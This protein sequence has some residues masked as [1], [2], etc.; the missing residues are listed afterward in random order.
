ME[1]TDGW[2]MFKVTCECKFMDKGDQCVKIWHKN[3]DSY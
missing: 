3:G 1:E 2:V